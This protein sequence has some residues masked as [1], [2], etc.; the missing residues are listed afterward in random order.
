MERV[1]KIECVSVF[2][3]IA[4]IAGRYSPCLRLAKLSSGQNWWN[5]WRRANS[6]AVMPIMIMSWKLPLLYT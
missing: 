6:S 2:V 3:P 4:T 5:G 1:T